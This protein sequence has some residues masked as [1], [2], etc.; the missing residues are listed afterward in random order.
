MTENLKKLIHILSDGEFHSGAELGHTLGLTRSAIW[1]LIRQ[2]SDWDIDVEARTNKG[3]KIA[4][5]ELLDAQQLK[6]HID[7]DSIL[8]IFDAIPSTN[9]YLMQIAASKTHR[10]HV[11]FAE[12]Q[13]SGKGRLGRPWISPYARNIYLSI[14]WH[15]D[16]D[17]SQL[18][19]LSLAIA[20]TIIDALKA[21]GI[22]KNIGLKWPNDVLYQQKKLAG[23]LIEASG[24]THS[25]SS[26]VVIG[27]G[28]NVDMPLSMTQYI[29]CP[30]ID[31]ATLTAERPSRNKLASL[32]LQHI[33]SNLTLFQTEGFS[34]FL[35]RWS[36]VDITANQP[37]TLLTPAGNISGIGHGID[38]QGHFTLTTQE[39]EIRHFASGEISLRLGE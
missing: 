23:V 9:D 6:A 35:S 16:K 33:F 14:L 11:C 32:L 17:L 24:E 12:K 10:I 21:Y 18:S 4:P 22:E 34:P 2:F 15:F 3:Y 37:V 27:V 36:A 26:T 39:G 7:T 1:K 25:H 20:L 28:L 5:L 30:Y 29:D 31:I 8:E 13:I 38:A 19:G